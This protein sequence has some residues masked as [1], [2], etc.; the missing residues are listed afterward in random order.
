MSSATDLR[1]VRPVKWLTV[2]AML[3]ALN[4]AM[5]SF[6]IPVPGGHLYLNDAIIC[7]AAILLDPLGAFIVGG[8]GAFLGDFFFYP[9]PMFVS[10]V[11]HGLQAVVVS[12]CAH[13]LFGERRGR[14]ALVGVI[15]GV[16]INVVGYSFGRAYVYATPEAAVLKFPF[17]VFQATFGAVVSMLLCFKAGLLSFWNKFSIR[18]IVVPG[19]IFCFCILIK[20]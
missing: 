3:M 8:V 6:S 14:A 1:K 2:T 13:K 17:Q 11:T 15:L 9:A 4:I 7:T 5:S 16:V 10:L 19:G 20:R 18:G 12:L